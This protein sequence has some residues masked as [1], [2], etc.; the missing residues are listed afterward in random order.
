MVEL[1]K[2]AMS[3]E[4]QAA[5]KTE[6]ERLSQARSVRD[7]AKAVI[8][9]ELANMA[10]YKR[11]DDEARAI[12]DAQLESHSIAR[13]FQDL[14]KNSGLQEALERINRPL[15]EFDE[16]VRQLTNPLSS[17][18]DLSERIYDLTKPLAPMAEL[19]RKIE[20][21]IRPLQLSESLK[22][23][24]AGISNLSAP[25]KDAMAK[26]DLGIPANDSF[27]HNIPEIPAHQPRIP[28]F[29]L[30]PNPAHKTN[31]LLQEMIVRTDQLLTVQGQQSAVIQELAQLTATSLE[32]ARMSAAESAE[33]TR[34]AKRSERVARWAFYIAVIS[35]L[36]S[37]A[38]STL[39]TWMS[40]QGGNES[41]ATLQA[42]LK[43]VSHDTVPDA[44]TVPLPTKPSRQ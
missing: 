10:A 38:F 9:A 7:E 41:E 39:Q 23:T 26:L 21:M 2:L 13:T 28:D 5:L 25:Y 4:A 17:I 30:P 16:S 33:A 8:D 32:H 6:L 3:E 34:S 22:D 20:D 36:V 24:L 1:S 11:L 12:Y 37:V 27:K 19:S 29:K 15:A 18:T 31:K 42:I 43:A 40:W 44:G 14:A 35:I